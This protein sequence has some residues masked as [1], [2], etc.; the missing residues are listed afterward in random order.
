MFR[1][2]NTTRDNFNFTSVESCALFL[3]GLRALDAY[4][5]ETEKNSPSQEELQH[6]LASANDKLGDCVRIY[7]DDRIPHFY[8]GIVLTLVNQTVYATRV[9]GMKDALFAQGRLMAFREDLRN[10]QPTL[11]PDSKSWPSDPEPPDGGPHSQYLE[12]KEAAAPF[13]DLRQGKWPLLAEAAREFSFA[14]AKGPE[15][16]KNTAVYNLA[17]VHGRRGDIDSL[18]K[19]LEVLDRINLVPRRSNDDIAL[20]LQIE[21][22]T[23]HLRARL[24][25]ST[26]GSKADFDR[27]WNSL[28]QMEAAISNSGL[29]TTYEIDLRADYLVKSGYVLYDQA[30]HECF[31]DS[32]RS[33][34]DAAASRFSDALDVRKS[35]NQAQ[36]YLAIARAL[37]SGVAERQAVMFLFG[38]WPDPPVGSEELMAESKKLLDSL[39]GKVAEG[40]QPPAPQI[41]E[42]EA[43][44]KAARE[45]FQRIQDKKDSLEPVETEE[46]QAMPPG[47]SK[48]GESETNEPTS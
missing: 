40:P 20:G 24:L 29:S 22:L 12:F 33:A 2:R 25:I 44:L 6:L 36:L 21:I 10:E 1:T 4:E 15:Q 18:R 7:P 38:L 8:H 5:Q 16:L 41:S 11:D 35:W 27:S 9:H 37:Q 3:E 46:E 47:K 17:Q 39:L 26:K 30:L 45:L 48:S 34:L 42:A 43:F 14:Q 31:T 28:E 23:H 32:P 13:S 19:G